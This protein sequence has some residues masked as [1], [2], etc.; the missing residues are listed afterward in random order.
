MDIKKTMNKERKDRIKRQKIRPRTF[1][2][3]QPEI[4]DE[5]TEE[6]YVPRARKKLENYIHRRLKWRNRFHIFV[7][8]I[9]ILFPR[10]KPITNRL[11]MSENK[12]FAD[13]VK[14]VVEKVVD[15]FRNI[16]EST[17]EGFGWVFVIAVIILGY[18]GLDVTEVQL[19][20]LYEIGAGIVALAVAFYYAVKDIFVRQE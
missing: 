19:M 8:A 3:S 7:D 13:R 20:E 9:G 10:I 12:S 5:W 17:F 15:A 16:Q 18:F 14:N 11:I 6:V 4:P 1:E 2:T